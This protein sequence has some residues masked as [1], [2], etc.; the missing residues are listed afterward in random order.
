MYT[1]SI[2]SYSLIPPSSN[3]GGK[4]K[5]CI[6]GSKPNGLWDLLTKMASETVSLQFEEIIFSFLLKMF[7][8]LQ[9]YSQSNSTDRS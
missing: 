3:Q 2:V 4:I 5:Q 7:F 1:H 9:C 8:K 6:V